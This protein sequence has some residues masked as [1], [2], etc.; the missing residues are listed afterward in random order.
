MGSPDRMPRTHR[1]TSSTGNDEAEAAADVPASFPVIW[2]VIAAI[3][4]GSVASYGEVAR[5]A[6]L[7]RRARLVAQALRA[8]PDERE[9]PWFRVIRSDGRIAFTPG[10]ASFRRQKALLQREGVT[11]NASGRV[12]SAV[13]AEQDL[14]TALWR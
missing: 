12:A 2:A 10:S 13:A 8:V 5:R 4:H 9:L 6:G 11:V 7:P 1:S 3:P 14:D